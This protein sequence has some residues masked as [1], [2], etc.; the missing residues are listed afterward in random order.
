MKLDL[1]KPWIVTHKGQKHLIAPIKEERLVDVSNVL[2]SN[3]WI[4]DEDGKVYIYYA[5]SDARMHIATS[6]LDQ[7]VDYCVNSPTDQ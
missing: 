1:E 4:K 6:N 7:L 5:S 3:G 2:F